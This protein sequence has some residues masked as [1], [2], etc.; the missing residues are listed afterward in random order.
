[1]LVGRIFPLAW[2]KPQSGLL[3]NGPCCALVKGLTYQISIAVLIGRLRIKD[4]LKLGLQK[5]PPWSSTMVAGRYGRC[6]KEEEEE[7]EVPNPTSYI[8][9]ASNFFLVQFASPLRQKNHRPSSSQ[10]PCSRPI[11]KSRPLYPPWLYRSSSSPPLPEE[12]VS[13]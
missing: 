11:G 9:S 5:S 7:R 3:E 4:T 2:T 6:H 1:M 10:S 12:T 13:F 8:L